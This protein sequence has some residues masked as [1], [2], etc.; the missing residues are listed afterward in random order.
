MRQKENYV[1]P[2]L[3]V[4]EFKVEK[5]FATSITI[6]EPET[7]LLGDLLIGYQPTQVD[8]HMGQAMGDNSSAFVNT[9]GDN[10]FFGNSETNGFF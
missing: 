10:G 5:G 8:M 4:V 7:A 2:E 9:E 6:P 3:T 1:A